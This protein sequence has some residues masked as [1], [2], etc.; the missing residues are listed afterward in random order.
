M[1][2]ITTGL[3]SRLVSTD[4]QAKA[5]QE[6][7][8]ISLARL[9]STDPA[10]R[11]ALAAEIQDAAINSGFFY[12]SDHGVPQSVIDGVFEQAKEFFA[13]PAEKKME[14]DMHNSPA[15][16]GYQ[17]LKGENVD[18]ANRGDVHEAW[19][20]GD[21][22]QVMREGKKNGNQWPSPTDLPEF[23]AKLQ[24][25][26][27]EI[28]AL[29]KRL[30]PLFALAL[31]LPED[32]FADKLKNPGST[33]R[34]LHYPPQFGPMDSK[35]IGIGAHSDYECFTL[36]LQHGDVQA[37]QVLNGAGEWV[38]A[39]PKPGTFVLNIGDQL[40][41]LSNSIFKST[42]HRAINRSGVERMSSPFFFGLDYDAVLEVLPSCV[43]DERP[44]LYEP[45]K[46]G[47]YV[48]KRLAET[49]V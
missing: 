35:E 41:L 4:T 46:A 31:D 38:E 17:P 32:Y 2:A 29:G 12:I 26:W 5:F 43:S 49:Y 30:F 20:M 36:L 11:K 34:I 8:V 33:M 19:D 16:K 42:I 1:A 25:A 22:S 15:F 40:Q 9:A 37:L 45:I 21:D 13:L 23:Q 6:L 18:P 27:D 44:A 10:E 7:P 48:E 3:G 39:P 24:R 28:M 14:M 47:D